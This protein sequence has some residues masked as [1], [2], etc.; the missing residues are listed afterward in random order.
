[1][2]FYM[3]PLI[4]A[5]YYPPQSKRFDGDGSDGVVLRGQEHDSEIVAYVDMMNHRLGLTICSLR[6]HV[7]E[8]GEQV[9]GKIWFSPHW[10][11]QANRISTIILVISE[12]IHHGI[13]LL[14][15][16]SLDAMYKHLTLSHTLVVWC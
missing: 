13:C 14:K 2:F 15:Y 8:I 3:F 5:I 7:E 4:I 16:A 1:M 6:Q 11:G 9:I 10:H 12:D